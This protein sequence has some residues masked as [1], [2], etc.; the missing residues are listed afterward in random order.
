MGRRHPFGILTSYYDWHIVWLTESDEFAS[1]P[2]PYNSSK[3]RGP[4][5]MYTAEAPDWSKSQ[6]GFVCSV[7]GQQ[8]S[9]S[10]AEWKLIGTPRIKWNDPDLPHLLVSAILK[11][12]SSP[13]DPVQL[14]TFD[15]NRSYIYVRKEEW[16]WDKP[17]QEGSLRYCGSRLAQFENVFLLADLGG[18][19]DGRVWLAATMKGEV[20]CLSLN[21][22]KIEKCLSKKQISGEEFG[23]V[24]LKFK[25]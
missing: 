11:M 3:V 25:S 10:S 16:S 17:N 4:L 1:S 21:F 14:S 13:V 2:M 15:P 24:M 12:T 9:E 6:E 8:S 19:A 5:H 23:D 20:K 18:G 22:Q 7:Y